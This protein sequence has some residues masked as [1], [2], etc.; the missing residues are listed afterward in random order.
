[1]NAIPVSSLEKAPAFQASKWLTFPLL[2]SVEELGD[3]LLTLHQ[4]FIVSLASINEEGQDTVSEQQFLSDYD[5]YIQSLKSGALPERNT[6][7]KTLTKGLSA[8]LDHFCKIPAGENK[9]LIRL[10]KPVIQ[11]QPYWFVYSEADNKFHSMTFGKE[12]I[13]WG[14]QFSYPQLFQDPVTKEV[15]KV[16]T[17]EAFPNNVLFKAMQKW[18][19]ANSQA[20]PFLIK[21]QRVNI[22]IRL[23]KQCFSWINQH[24]ALI[25]KDMKIFYDS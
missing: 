6:F 1:M 2:C 23:G 3:L 17:S 4:P 10:T 12:T 18:M 15:H 16:L 21:N 14:I 19:R 8:K 20:T 22:P 25:A 11:L 5:Q 24:P 13:T 9:Y 7:Q